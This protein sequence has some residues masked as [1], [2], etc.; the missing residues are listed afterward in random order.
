VGF[1][2]AGVCSVAMRSTVA[3]ALLSCSGFGGADDALPTEMTGMSPLRGSGGVGGATTTSAAA[4][5][6][7]C[8]GGPPASTPAVTG[9][10]NVSYAVLLRSLF[11]APL[12]NVVARVCQAADLACATPLGEFRGIT[13]ESLLA[14]QVPVAFAGFLEVQV[15]G[16]VPTLFQMRVPVLRDTVDTQPLQPI[17]T[18]GV[19]QLSGLLNIEAVPELGLVSVAAIDCRGQRAPGAAFNNNLGGRGFYFADGVPSLT[20]SSTDILGLGGFINMPIRLVEITAEVEA[21]GRL[22][23]TRNVLPRAGWLTVVQVRPSALP[24]E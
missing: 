21:D 24:F 9:A 14:V 23:G 2:R 13:A 22:I 7:S 10:G 12:N 8:L 3:C 4:A 17:P 20:A 11:G 16:H 6:W 15:D 1:L 5:D 19:A 18:A